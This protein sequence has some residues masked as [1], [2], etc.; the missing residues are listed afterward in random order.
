MSPLNLPDD[1]TGWSVSFESTPNA[2]LSVALNDSDN[3]VDISPSVHYF[4]FVDYG[5]KTIQVDVLRFTDATAAHI[6]EILDAWT[7]APPSVAS[8]I[9]DAASKIDPSKLHEALKLLEFIIKLVIQYGGP[10]VA[11][12]EALG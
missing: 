4:T 12:I 3:F 6:Q 2:V 9:A 1:F 8:Q 7:T 11:I 10:A 5:A